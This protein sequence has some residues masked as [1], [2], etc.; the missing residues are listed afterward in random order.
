MHGSYC[1]AHCGVVTT[2]LT[3]PRVGQ[4]TRGCHL[5][6][7]HS[8]LY[9][10]SGYNGRWA[11]LYI[12]WTFSRRMIVEAHISTKNILGKKKITWSPLWSHCGRISHWQKRERTVAGSR[13]LLRCYCYTF[14]IVRS[15]GD[16][17]EPVQDFRHCDIFPRRRK[18]VCGEK[19]KPISMKN[20]PLYSSNRSTVATNSGARKAFWTHFR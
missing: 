20:G 16:A 12:I 10:S 9:R 1:G 7:R 2:S 3:S 15:D 14:K 5:Q 19:T 13:A 6:P 18:I 4:T 11:V 8:S 17:R